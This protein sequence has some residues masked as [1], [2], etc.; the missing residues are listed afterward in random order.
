[1]DHELI[2]ETFSQ[3]YE[4]TVKNTLTIKNLLRKHTSGLLRC[5]AT[6]NNITAPSET[7]VKLKMLCKKRK[8]CLKCSVL[9]LFFCFSVPPQGAKI[10]APSHPLTSGRTY[11]ISCSVWGSNP[12]AR[13]EWYQGTRQEMRPLHAFNQTVRDG[14]NLTVSWIR[15][16]PE[17]GHHKQTLTCRGANE[18]LLT[19][20][21][22]IVEDYHRLEVFCKSRH[23]KG[24]D[25][26]KIDPIFHAC[27]NQSK[28]FQ[29]SAEEFLC[30]QKRLSA[31]FAGL[32]AAFMH[33]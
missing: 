23:Q 13:V 16:A 21:T 2:D 32:A 5:V 22:Q 9:R 11:D 8:K 28:N 10:S 15:F 14:G 29:F 30:N 12:P 3:T 18:E 19:S 33:Y 7:A 24:F 31:E 20:A 4:G 17:P 25:C 6:N 26:P 1:M 27:C